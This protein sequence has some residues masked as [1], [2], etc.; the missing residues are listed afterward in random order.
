MQSGCTTKS[1]QVEGL[2]LGDEIL[3]DPEADEE[4]HQYS[5]EEEQQGSDE[6]N[7]EG[8][9]SDKSSADPGG[10]AALGES[11]LGGRDSPALVTEHS[12]T[13][14]ALVAC[15]GSWGAVIQTD[16]GRSG[17]VGSWGNE[18]VL[19]GFRQK[20]IREICGSEGVGGCVINGN[21]ARI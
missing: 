16:P 18:T 17:E 6:D 13:F 4:E 1:P 5:N 3:A 20:A 12:K 10:S 11:L 2:D 8:Q 21:G 15:A 14:R 9:G 7:S 19:A